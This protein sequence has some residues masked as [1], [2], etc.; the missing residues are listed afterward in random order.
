V[1]SPLG[2]PEGKSGAA[3]ALLNRGL[4]G[5]L[6]GLG[7]CVV[8]LAL[9]GAWPFDRVAAQTAA[10]AVQ[11]IS[12]AEGVYG[13][14]VPAS[15]HADKVDFLF[16]V[17]TWITGIIFVVVEILLVVF[18]VKYRHRTS[19]GA[20]PRRATYTH[21][22]RRL[23]IAW[24]VTPALL[25]LILVLMTRSSWRE[26]RYGPEPPEADST[27]VEVTAQ[28]F[29]WN[30]R[31]PGTAERFNKVSDFAPINQ[32][33]VPVNKPVLISLRSKDVLHSF[34]LP[35]MRVKL[36]AVPGMTGKVWFTP[37][38]TGVYEIACAELCGAE[39]WKMRGTVTVDT[40]EAYDAWL[41]KEAEFVADKP[42]PAERQ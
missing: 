26:I 6:V 4:A 8:I 27:V 11:R 15:A 9:A 3:A 42:K 13:L 23:E 36:D 39:H 32:F 2:P 37:T 30:I 38:R 28:Q 22:N 34:W 7:L 1:Y 29:Q 24:T 20:P 41:K 31:M 35:N 25:L 21:G 12:G 40:P 14:P 16:W 33:H 17:I 5:A 19:P 10:P 18:A